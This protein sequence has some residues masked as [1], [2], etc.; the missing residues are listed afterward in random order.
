MPDPIGIA[1][2]SIGVVSLG[3]QI[4]GGLTKFLDAYANRDDQI[5]RA[6][7]HLKHLESNLKIISNVIPDF[8]SEHR[9][10]SDVVVLNLK[11]CKD[12]MISLQAELEKYESSASASSKATITEAK[13]KLKYPFARTTIAELDDRLTR[14][15]EYLSL[16]MIGLNL[17]SFSSINTKVSGLNITAQNQATTLIKIKAEAISW[18]ETTSDRLLRLHNNTGLLAG[19]IDSLEKQTR[20]QLSHLEGRIQSSQDSTNRRLERMEEHLQSRLSSLLMQVLDGQASSTHLG[21]EAILTGRL[22]SKPSLLKDTPRSKLPAMILPKRRPGLLHAAVTQGIEK[23]NVCLR[24][25]RIFILMSDTLSESR[26]HPHCPVYKARDTENKQEWTITFTGLQRLLST[27]VS[28]GCSLT[29]G[30]GG[31]SISPVF[32][33]CAMVDRE[34]SPAFRI[35]YLMN[36]AIDELTLEGQVVED[37]TFH[38]FLLYGVSQMKAVY[39]NGIASPSDVD[40]TGATVVDNLIARNHMMTAVYYKYAQMLVFALVSL[41]IPSKNQGLMCNSLG[42]GFQH[43]DDHLGRAI[44]IALRE[45]PGSLALDPLCTSFIQQDEK[46]LRL[47]LAKQP[48]LFSRFDEYSFRNVFYHLA[49]NWPAGFSILLDSVPSIITDAHTL[50]FSTPDF[51]QRRLT[52]L[53]IAVRGGAL[54]STSKDA[55]TM[56]VDCNCSE[57][58]EILL[59]HNYFLSAADVQSVLSGDVEFQPQCKMAFVL[60][61]HL[62]LWRE[63]L[64]RL[65]VNHFPERLT[66]TSAKETSLLDIEAPRAVA[67]LESIGVPPYELF[68][69]KQGD[70]RLAPGSQA[71]DNIHYLISRDDVAQLAFNIGFQDVEAAS[72]SM[73]PLMKAIHNEPWRSHNPT[74]HWEWLA[75]H[76]SEPARHVPWGNGEQLSSEAVAPIPDHTILHK[77]AGFMAPGHPKNEYDPRWLSRIRDSTIGDSCSCACSPNSGGCHPLTIHLSIYILRICSFFG[78]DMKAAIDDMLATDFLDLLCNPSSDKRIS[79]ATETMFRSLTFHRL[80]I[81][82]TCC[83]SLDFEDMTENKIPIDYGS[84]FEEL[85]SEDAERVCQLNELLAELVDQY[86]HYDGPISAFIR[87]PWTQRMDLVDAEERKN[88][89]SERERLAVTSIGVI[90]NDKEECGSREDSEYDS[91]QRKSWIEHMDMVANGEQNISKPRLAYKCYLVGSSVHLSRLYGRLKGGFNICD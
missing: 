83:A 89:W 11:R 88:K 69:L 57:S 25:G 6:L 35:A 53:E 78:I 41:G 18:H 91:L 2:T 19:N 7:E 71:D 52:L 8:E 14:V 49:V 28:V 15:L 79:E 61:Q 77:S 38:D 55:Q 37:K 87:G 10:S 48:E 73:T 90:P 50:S 62:K 46:T 82:H 17:G 27:A 36:A 22:L 30:A 85:R 86:G 34:Q 75:Q 65:L 23:S 68:G 31:G 80:G 59:N 54:L 43:I 51:P 58:L 47:T 13:K 56:C 39:A 24:P 1:G 29:Y 74:Y 20:T 12:E 60:L 76:G 5:S 3:L 32:R 72:H 84:D 42:R 66:R 40:I 45:A 81:R 44:V 21:V 9:A 4:Y 26:H 16:A 67:E 33:Y 63:R 70:Y 64:R